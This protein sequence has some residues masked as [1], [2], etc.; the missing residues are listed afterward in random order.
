[1]GSCLR[2]RDPV[3]KINVEYC[4]NYYKETRESSDGYSFS[5]PELFSLS[6]IKESRHL[7]VSHIR[8]KFKISVDKAGNLSKN[9]VSV[10]SGSSNSDNSIQFNFPLTEVTS[11]LF[12][13]TLKDATNDTVLQ[14]CGIT[15]II[16]VIGP[17]HLF[18]K[19]IR[20]AHTFMNNSGKTELKDIIKKLWPIVEESQQQG[21]ALLVYGVNG[22]NRSAAM[23]VSILMKSKRKKVYEVL[24]LL[25]SKRPWVGINEQYMK[26]LLKM[27]QELFGPSSAP[28]NRM[29][30]GSCD[31]KTTKTIIF[32]DRISPR[33]P[34]TPINRL[35]PKYN[36][37]YTTRAVKS[38]IAT[39][40]TCREHKKSQVCKRSRD[41]IFFSTNVG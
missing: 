26:Q 38:S 35:R 3:T 25:K 32:R 31:R 11:Q 19:G 29:V 20:Y 9:T 24:K 39:S 28:S 15:H 34:T 6:Q 41:R 30:E 36:S 8:K 17:G 12:L 23:M 14:D 16:S 2:T 1:M 5:T 27:E 13:G 21:K 10:S 7:E 4:L 18:F 40:I 33:M 22:Q 37:S